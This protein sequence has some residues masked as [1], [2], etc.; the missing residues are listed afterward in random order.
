M[1][2]WSRRGSIAAAASVE[3]LCIT[4]FLTVFALLCQFS[5]GTSLLSCAHALLVLRC[6]GLDAEDGELRR[7]LQS[8]ACG[9]YRVLRKEPKGRDVADGDVFHFN[10]EFRDPLMRIKIPTIQ[11]VKEVR[12]EADATREKIM[13][14]RQ[15]QIDAAIVRIMKSRKTLA[16]TQ[17]MSELLGQL[18]FP[19]VPA[20]CKKRIDSLID[21]DYL[22]RDEADPSVY[23]YLA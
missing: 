10:G 14:D 12:A 8:L 20:D 19:G 13:Q 2:C 23:N 16:H 9:K 7:T 21:R 22:E 15:Y 3:R 5:T 11:A 6:V 1:S 4:G 17:L 18:R